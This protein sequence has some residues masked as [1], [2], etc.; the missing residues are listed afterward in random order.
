MYKR[1]EENTHTLMLS[2]TIPLVIHL[3]HKAEQ[4]SRF[5]LVQITLSLLH[6]TFSPFCYLLLYPTTINSKM[7]KKGVVRVR[8][9]WHQVSTCIIKIL[10]RHGS[11][12]GFYVNNINVYVKWIVLISIPDPVKVQCYID[13]RHMKRLQIYYIQ[14]TERLSTT[15]TLDDRL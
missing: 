1:F 2:M 8:E 11:S 10:N 3:S 6:P 13:L 9:N 14:H 7:V 5:L 12:K 4:K 15:I